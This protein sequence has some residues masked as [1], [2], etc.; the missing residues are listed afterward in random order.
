MTITPDFDTVYGAD[1]DPY[2]V[3]SSF[4]ERRKLQI[5]LA[6]LARAGYT[7]AWD[8]AC[9]TGHLAA[10]L[11]NRCATVLATDGSPVAV[12]LARDHCRDQSNVDVDTLTVPLAP[13]GQPIFDLVVLAEFL[14]YLTPADRAATLMLLQAH[15]SPVAEVVAVHWRH[16]P[17]DAYLSGADVQIEVVDHLLAGGWRHSVHLDDPDFVVDTLVRGHDE[18]ER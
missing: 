17:H 18:A 12:R 15:V 1:P 11:A 4:Y 16:H 9:G 10:E 14:Y 13:P 8:P 6:V 7:S 3:G 2:R 5:V